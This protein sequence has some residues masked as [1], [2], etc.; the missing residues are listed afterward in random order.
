[1]LPLQSF[2][3]KGLTR[4]T[5]NKKRNTFINNISTFHRFSKV[6][7]FLLYSLL[8]LKTLHPFFIVEKK[9][10]NI[11]SRLYLVSPPP[12]NPIQQWNQHPLWRLRTKSW[13]FSFFQ[14]LLEEKSYTAT[15]WH[16]SACP[17]RITT[18]AHVADSVLL[19]II[20]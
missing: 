3:K 6:I 19:F 1:M 16:F 18:Y 14:P 7:S 8:W 13:F 2:Q 5:G 12:L 4:K 17:T 9:D 20:F 11:L 10:K 15:L